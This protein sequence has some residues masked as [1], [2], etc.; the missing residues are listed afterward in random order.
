VRSFLV[1][2][3]A[4]F[5]GSHLADA[6]LAAG[7]RVRVLDN[8]STGQRKNLDACCEIVAA[9]VADAAAVCSAMAG[10]DGCFHLAAISSVAQANADWRGTHHVNQTGT[11]TVLEAARDAGRIPV[12]LASS[13]AVYG[14]LGGAVAREDACCRPLSAYGAD[15]LGA[16][17]HARVA[18]HVHGVP[19]LALRLFNV[20]GPRQHSASPY[21]GVVSIF[22]DRLARGLPLLIHGDGRQERDFVFVADAV[23]H[24]LAAMRRLR[25]AEGCHVLNVCTGRAITI[26]QLAEALA[27]LLG[28]TLRIAHG[29]ARPGDIR[30]SLGDPSA[31]T[32]FLG[33]AARTPLA[34]GLARTLHA[35]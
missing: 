35:G 8:F 25:E 5:I 33:V 16:E 14:D 11:I 20:Y 15:K 27:A 32:A 17:L 34:E 10:C 19:T 12:V 30:R 7:D 26:L 22:A 4:G 1:T 28:R 24:L 23:A 9:D 18:W 13:A 2:G 21:S 3:G 29:P 31:A 6:L